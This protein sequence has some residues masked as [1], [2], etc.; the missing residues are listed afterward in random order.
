MSHS[1]ESTTRLTVPT[2]NPTPA[3]AR[4]GTA[5]IAANA[6]VVR[7]PPPSVPIPSGITT[8]AAAGGARPPA[9]AEPTP[10]ADETGGSRS[11]DKRPDDSQLAD[12][13]W[14]PATDDTRRKKEPCGRE[15]RH[16]CE[17]RDLS[18]T[19]PV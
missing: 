7:S 9:M 8:L 1:P 16:D 13:R 15:E 12:S 4:L 5:I 11:E 2:P 6:S 3:A 17:P 19:G 14:Q 10:A 18:R